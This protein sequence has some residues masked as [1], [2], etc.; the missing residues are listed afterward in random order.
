MVDAE[1]A[2]IKGHPRE[3][4]KLFK[5]AVVFAGR[6]GFTNDQALANER[7]SEFFLRQGLHDD[8]KYHLCEALK[9]YLQWGAYAKCEKLQKNHKMLVPTLPTEIGTAN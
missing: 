7:I 5:E 4:E 3:A 8:A 1:T 9:L 6:R 2:D